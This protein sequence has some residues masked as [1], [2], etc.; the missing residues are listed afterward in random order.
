[1]YNCQMSNLRNLYRIKVKSDINPQKNKDEGIESEEAS[2]N[3][4][5]CTYFK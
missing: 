2:R 1:M 3:K 4:R 5:M